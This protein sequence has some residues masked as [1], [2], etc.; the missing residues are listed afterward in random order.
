M[1]KQWILNIMFALD[2]LCNSFLG[3]DPRETMSSR[4]GKKVVAGKCPVCKFLCKVLAH[5]LGRD[6]CQDSIEPDTGSRAI[7]K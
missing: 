3:G 2:E 4:M 7:F 5:V 6:H 1:V